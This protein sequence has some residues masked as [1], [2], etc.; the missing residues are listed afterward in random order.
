M[1]VTKLILKNWRNFRSVDVELGLRVF[2]AGPNAS[3]KSNLLDVFAFLKDL[4]KP[5][6]GLQNAVTERGGISKLRCLAARQYPDVEIEVHLADNGK[7]WS[8]AIGI[9]QEA[10]GYRQPYLAYERVTRGSQLLL[11]RPDESDSKDRLRLTQTH[12]EQISANAG[13]RDLGRF[14]DSVTYLHLV[15]QLLR[16]PEAFSGPG[17]P[18]DPY[19]RSFLERVARTSDGTRK[20]RLRKIEAALR[21]AVP[22]L[23]E[24]TD[25]K[26]EAGIPHLEAVYEH[27]RPRGAK[28]RED[29]FSDGT[30][31]LIGLLWSLLDGD[32]MLLLEEPELSLNSGIIRK[33]PELMYRIQKQ[34]K[35]QIMLSTHSSDLLSDP[36]INGDEV[37]LL[38][39]GEEGTRVELAS[40]N[41]EI[42]DLLE[43]G[44]TIADAALPRTVP[45]GISQLDLFE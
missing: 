14:F 32:S 2:V 44:L 36:G 41:K 17:I 24:L 23:K 40:S 39:P 19:G 1:F 20:A 29:Q 3:G 16:H 21:V 43:G 37:L 38:T 33:L 8:Y 25:V 30:L 18:G 45:S 7:R 42:R 35:R 10:R 12:L 27:W 4:A 13:F 34:K 11:E 26:D 28:Q 22:Q 31:R 9:K 5:G 6:G 15:P